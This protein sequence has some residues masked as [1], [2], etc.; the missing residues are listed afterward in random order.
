FRKRELPEHPARGARF[1]AP[2]PRIELRADAGVRW[3]RGTLFQPSV[4]RVSGGAPGRRPRRSGSAGGA[5][6]TGTGAGA[7]LRL[8]SNR[9]TNLGRSP[10]GR[11]RR[12]TSMNVLIITQYFWP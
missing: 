4:A 6:R 3:G 1:S 10:A 9:L 11:I 2:A 7:G 8:G 5:Q 12:L